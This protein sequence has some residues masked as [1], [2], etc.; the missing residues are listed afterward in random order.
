[1]YRQL[2][3][4]KKERVVAIYNIY[5]NCHTTHR[6]ALRQGIQASLS[7]IKRVIARYKT[8]RS[9][10]R[11]RGSG[12]SR[13]TSQ[14]IDRSLRT[15]AKRDRQANLGQLAQRLHTQH[16]VSVSRWT[17]ARRLEEGGLARRPAAKRPQLNAAQK[18]RRRAFAETLLRRKV[19]WRLVKFSDE[20]IFS[21]DNFTRRALVTRRLDERHAPGCVFPTAKWAI[22]LHVWGLIGWDGV[23]PLKQV[24]GNLNAHKYVTE[25]IN[26]LHQQL[27]IR[28]R[29]RPIR[30]T[31]QQNL[32]PAH[33]ARLTRRFL[34]ERRIRVL[35]WPG[36]SP[37]L[38]PIEHVWSHVAHRVRSHGRP[39]SKAQLWEWV[40][41][42]WFAT[43]I[44]YI[45]QLLRSMTRR[46]QEVVQNDG[47][48]T[49]Y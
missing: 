6:H 40:Q 5:R 17:V 42:E 34:Q 21:S 20:K 35:D 12:P 11:R 48:T 31:F 10:K 47:D 23:G 18:A 46:L 32:A 4:A 22:K 13:N 38:N 26:D 25:I 15:M 3:E 14:I 41:T 44:D 9:V 33:S 1:M 49:H 28:G 24:V 7:T 2:T 29:R 8:S 27:T 19:N 30:A 39:A 16:G 37:D 36:N 43:P 45:R